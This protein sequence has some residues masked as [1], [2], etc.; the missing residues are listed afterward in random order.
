MTAPAS[1]SS[2]CPSS[3]TTEARCNRLKKAFDRF[4]DIEGMSDV[5]ASRM[6][7]DMEI[8]I[9]VDLS[10][11]TG[12]SRSAIFAN[13]PAPIQVNYL[14][15]PGTLGADY[16][17]YII[18]DRTVI[19]EQ[20]QPLYAEK[21]V[22]LPDT[23]NRADCG[24][25]LRPRPAVRKRDCPRPASS[26]LLQ[27]QLQVRARDVRHLDA[28]AE[29]CGRQRAVDVRAQCRREEQPS[30]RSRGP[31]RPRRAPDLRAVPSGDR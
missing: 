26:L 16:I 8:D 6:L 28:S 15:Y 11:Y 29:D 20:H 24:L 7:K 12:A 4:V 2:R 13:R 22:Y 31:R 5:D 23:A 27:Q 19:P 17:D 1:K 10:G 3:S 18:A 25:L 9:A 14:G 30:A 21:V